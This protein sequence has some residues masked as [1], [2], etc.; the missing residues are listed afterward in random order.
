MASVTYLGIDLHAKN[1]WLYAFD[2]EGEVLLN[3]PAP[4]DWKALA[5][6]LARCPGR[7][8]AAVEAGGNWPWLVYGLQ[9]R[10]C[11]VRLLHPNSVAP[12]RQ[13]R[14]KNDRIDAALLASLAAEPW[15]AKGAWICPDDWLWL[16]AQLRARQQLIGQRTMVRNRIHGLLKQDNRRP[17]VGAIFGPV[18][19]AWLQEQELPEGMRHALQPLQAVEQAID[20][21]VE[22]LEKRLWPLIKDNP[23][24]KRLAA[25][26]QAGPVTAVTI[27]LEARS[28]SIT[29]TSLPFACASE[30]SPT[31]V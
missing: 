21:Q 14:A 24:M 13:S 15:R 12:Y 26:P 20:R 23:L 22:R 27:V 7:I 11:E 31:F 6:A 4:N 16:R 5:P 1:S 9:Q 30:S 2:D 3:A 28:T 25:L 17:P 10:G 29:T 18:G 19:Q 8:V